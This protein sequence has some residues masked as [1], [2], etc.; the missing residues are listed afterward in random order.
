M[1]EN[2]LLEKIRQTLPPEP[3]KN[4]SE[5]QTAYFKNQKEKNIHRIYVCGMWLLFGMVVIGSL[6][7]FWHHFLPEKWCWLPASTVNYVT[8]ILVSALLSAL[9]ALFMEKKIRQIK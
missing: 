6:I 7:L 5:E 9:L 1:P 3:D 8:G 2:R 4:S